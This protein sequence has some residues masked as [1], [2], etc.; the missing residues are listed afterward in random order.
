MIWVSPSFPLRARFS[1]H[2]LFAARLMQARQLCGPSQCALRNRVGLGKDR[3]SS[4]INRYERQVT[5]I[6]FDKLHTMLDSQFGAARQRQ[7]YCLR[8]VHPAQH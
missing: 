8:M 4:R 2:A 7:A 1:P 6:G 5:A 3:G